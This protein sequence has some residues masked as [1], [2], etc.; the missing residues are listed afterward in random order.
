MAYETIALEKGPISVLTIDRPKKLNALNSQ[1]IRELELALTELE[2]DSGVRVLIVTGAG[3]KSF[4]AGA[5]IQELHDA[6]GLEGEAT[7]R[8]G[9]ALFRRLERAAFATIAAVNG[10]ALG[11]GLEL[12]LACDI[13]I[14]S[15]RAKVGLPEVTLGIIPGYAGTQRLAKVVGQGRALEL[16]L[17]GGMIDAAE[18]YRIGLV[19]HVAAPEEVMDKARSIAEA[20]T[21]VGPLAVAKAKELVYYAEDVAFDQ[22]C[23]TEAAAFGVLSASKDK[24]EGTKA[25]L[26]KRKPEFVGA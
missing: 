14:A 25:F 9:Q 2:S 11:G 1:V 6:D 18:A 21:Q 10:F 4:V 13:R 19:N 16:V 8:R 15:E 3:E 23:V 17:T 5:D 24:E 20:I 26:E 7:S 22:G 12:A